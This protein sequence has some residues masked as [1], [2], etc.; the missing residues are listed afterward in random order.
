MPCVRGLE[1]E[2]VVDAVQAG[3]DDR[4]QRQVG[5]EVRAARAVLEAQR[6]AVPDDAQRARAVVLAP[7]DRR[8]R[9]RT[10]GVALVGV[11]VGRHQQR[12]LAQ[13]G[14]LAGEEGL[15]HGAIGGEHRSAVGRIESEKWMWHELPSRSLNFAMKLIDMP[16]WAAISLAAFL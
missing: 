9:E 6:V 11:D 12:Q 8:G 3:G 16:S 10:L 7:G 14:E 13:A 4:A 2:P 5:V 1:L 15:E